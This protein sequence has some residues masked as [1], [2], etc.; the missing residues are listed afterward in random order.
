VRG[1]G[2]SADEYHLGDRDL[3][4]PNALIRAAKKAYHMAD[5]QDP[6]KEI[7]VAEIYDAFTYQELLWCEGLGFCERG[8]G[9]RLIESGV[10]RMGGSLPVNPSGGVLSA[11]PVLVAGLARIAEVTIQ[12]RGEG[13]KRQVEGAKIGLAHGINGACGQAHCVWVLES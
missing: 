12:L 13:N 7:D 3:A 11:H 1:V 2:H 9:G 4:E 6:F 8:K 5:I 10:T